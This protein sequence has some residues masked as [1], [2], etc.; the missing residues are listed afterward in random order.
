MYVLLAQAM[1]AETSILGWMITALSTFSSLVVVLSAALI[2]FGAWYLVKNKRPVASLAAYLVLL[3]VP[4]LV[5][6]CAWIFG[7]IK[8]LMAI[9]AVPDLAIP[10]QHIAS[11]L[12]DSLSSVLFAI[13]VSVPTYLVLAYGMLARD[14]RSP[15]QGAQS[16]GSVQ[17]SPTHGA[18]DGQLARAVQ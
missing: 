11:G 13:L 17:K 12:A 18:V 14:F 15:S 10:S 6:V 4:L 5:A 7:S 16:T 3:P 9:A 2:F 8:S 1:P